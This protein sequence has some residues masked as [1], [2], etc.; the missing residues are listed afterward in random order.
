MFK[1]QGSLRDD[2]TPFNISREE[3]LDIFKNFTK[4]QEDALNTIATRVLQSGE[5]VPPWMLRIQMLMPH[6][7]ASWRGGAPLGPI[8]VADTVK[9][10][11][12][13]QA[14]IAR[15]VQKQIVDVADPVIRDILMRQGAREH[16]VK[17]LSAKRWAN[18]PLHMFPYKTGEYAIDDKEHGKEFSGFVRAASL[19]DPLARLHGKKSRI[20]EFV[21]IN[22]TPE[23]YHIIVYKGVP[24]RALKVL[25][26]QLK[27][28]I[29]GLPHTA[30][31]ELFK[32][33]ASKYQILISAERLKKIS[34]SQLARFII[35]HVASKKKGHYIH[36]VLL[37]TIPGGSLMKYRGF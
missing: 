30:H 16:M 9:A 19:A 31:V 37:Q 26:K 36:F 7:A 1:L 3:M 2:G 21:S 23:R 14:P 17:F 22:A 20:G 27:K 12:L 18:Q 24:P 10:D 15:L 8:E 4:E 35:E 13:P 29:S 25:C 32:E 11:V 34:V 6:L 5:D 28:H 33:V